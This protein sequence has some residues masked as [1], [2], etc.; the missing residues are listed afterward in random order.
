MLLTDAFQSAH[1]LRRA[2]QIAN[3]TFE[4]KNRQNSQIDKLLCLGSM[5]SKTTVATVVIAIMALSFVAASRI[6]VGPSVKMV[7]I[8]HTAGATHGASGSGLRFVCLLEDG[9]KVNV[10]PPDKTPSKIGGKI[11]LEK[12]EMLLGGNRYVFVRYLN[13]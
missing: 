8:L 1:A 13:D 12:R 11:V 5:P 3:V 6:P 9:K 7:G 2:R 10:F 4:M